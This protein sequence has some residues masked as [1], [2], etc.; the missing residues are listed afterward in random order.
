[1]FLVQIEWAKEM[2]QEK[3]PERKP[4][5]LLHCW[6]KLQYEQKWVDLG[7][8]TSQSSKKTQ[9]FLNCKSKG[10]VYQ[11]LMKVSV[12]MKRMDQVIHHQGKEGQ[13]VRRRRKHTEVKILALKE[14][15]FTWRQWK[16]CGQREKKDEE[17]REVKKKRT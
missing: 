8:E 13:M 10:H 5:T 17:M 3:D 6:T 12:L 1:M 11:E 14:K 7:S 16:N 2:Y 4:F 15:A 9:E